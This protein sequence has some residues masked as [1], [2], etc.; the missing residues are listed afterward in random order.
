[1]GHG[2]GLAGGV[3]DRREFFH[4]VFRLEFDRQID[5]DTEAKFHVLALVEGASVELHSLRDQ[6]RKLSFKYSETVIVPACFGKYRIVNQGEGICKIV[7][8]RLK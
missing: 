5:D 8:A 7:K 3:G 6:G 1:M 4:I 2:G